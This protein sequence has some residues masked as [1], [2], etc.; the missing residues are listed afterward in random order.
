MDGW[1]AAVMKEEM[2]WQEQMDK[3]LSRKPRP[4][5]DAEELAEELDVRM[6]LSVF[7]ECV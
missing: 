4:S 3:I 7:F 5:G 6:T 2:R 1:I